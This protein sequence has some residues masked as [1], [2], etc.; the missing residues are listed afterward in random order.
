MPSSRSGNKLQLQ[1]RL[2]RKAQQEGALVTERRLKVEWQPRPSVK[3][4]A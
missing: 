3:A 4:I 2:Q 1:V